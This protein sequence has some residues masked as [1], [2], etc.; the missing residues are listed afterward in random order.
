[1]GYAKIDK[2]QLPAS[3]GSKTKATA[4]SRWWTAIQAALGW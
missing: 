2:E 4:A 3:L 1:M